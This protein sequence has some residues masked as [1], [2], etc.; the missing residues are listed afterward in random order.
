MTGF[1][2]L[3]T[4]VGTGR[5]EWKPTETDKR[6]EYPSEKESSHV[7]FTI[8]GVIVKKKKKNH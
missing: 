4:T 1:D 2:N 3:H 8:Y 5:K 6:D 7:M